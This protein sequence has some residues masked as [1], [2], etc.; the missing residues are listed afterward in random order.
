MPDAL[1]SIVELSL[2]ADSEMCRLQASKDVLGLL[3]VNQKQ[4]VEVDVNAKRG[5]E[6]VDH[7]L[8][9]T[10][11]RLNAGR[12]AALPAASAEVVVLK[13]EETTVVLRQEENENG[14]RS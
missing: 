5:A 1:N 13:T 2:G 14:E 6:E 7:E 8:Q 3:G 9:K 11:E 4:S 10:L 12:M